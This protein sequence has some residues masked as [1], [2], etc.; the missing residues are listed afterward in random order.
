MRCYHL[1]VQLDFAENCLH[2]SDAR[3]PALDGM[4][5]VF[6]DVVADSVVLVARR[7]IPQAK[8]GVNKV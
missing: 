1:P 3:L 6:G 5:C 4:H 7:T 8:P 2:D